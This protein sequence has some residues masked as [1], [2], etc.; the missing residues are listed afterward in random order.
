MLVEPLG[1]E[2]NTSAIKP[3][4]PLRKSTGC[5]ATNTAA[6]AGIMPTEPLA[7]SPSP[8]PTAISTT[9]SLTRS[10][11]TMAKDG[12]AVFLGVLPAACR[13]HVPFLR[14]RRPPPPRRRRA[15]IKTRNLR[16]DHLKAAGAGLVCRLQIILPNETAGRLSIADHPS[17][18]LHG[19]A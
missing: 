15:G 8:A 7:V 10:T 6:P 14:R 12:P 19:A 11:A 3:D 4:A 5:V 9:P 17:A 1:K 18:P 16:L 2:T 13:R